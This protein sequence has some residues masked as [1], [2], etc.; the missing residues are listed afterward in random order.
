MLEELYYEK[1]SIRFPRRNPTHPCILASLH[2]CILASLHPCILAS[3]NVLTAD[4]ACELE[5]SHRS[6]ALSI[7]A[8]I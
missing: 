1:F 2:P 8:Q 4:L 3:L 6:L 7:Q 5:G